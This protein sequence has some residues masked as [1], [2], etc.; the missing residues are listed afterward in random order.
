MDPQEEVAS[1]FSAFPLVGG[2]CRKWVK[3]R[4]T[5]CEQMSSGLPLKE[6]DI[7]QCSRHVS[8]VPDSDI[9]NSSSLRPAVW[10]GAY[11]RIAFDAVALTRFQAPNSSTGSAA[12]RALSEAI[13]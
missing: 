13:P 4:R 9:G 5:H 2:R 6:A 8:K 10:F 1:D 7:A 3:Q 11:R 12:T